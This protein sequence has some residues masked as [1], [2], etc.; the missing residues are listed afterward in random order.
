MKENVFPGIWGG[1]GTIQACATYSKIRSKLTGWDM[2]NAGQPS[3]K[4]Q[5]WQNASNSSVDRLEWNRIPRQARNTTMSCSSWNSRNTCKVSN[6]LFQQMQSPTTRLPRVCPYSRPLLL[7]CPFSS[8]LSDVTRV[9]FLVSSPPTKMHKH[10]EWCKACKCAISKKQPACPWE[11]I[12]WLP[13]F[14]QDVWTSSWN[15]LKQLQLTWD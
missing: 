10:T 3:F 6:T 8:I 7:H 1:L 13:T 2:P 12:I 14:C 9:L 15:G 4:V 5:Q 11:P